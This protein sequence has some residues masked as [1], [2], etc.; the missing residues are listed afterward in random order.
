MRDSK[1]GLRA[2]GLALVAA[3]GL[4]AFMAVAAQAE[5]LT[6]G[7]KPGL[8]LVNGAA[9]A[10]GVAFEVNQ[11]GT[12]ALSVPGRNLGILCTSGVIKGEFKSDTEALGNAKFTGCTAWE[13]AD[14]EKGE[15][16][17]NKLACV[18]HEPIEVTKAK[19][20]PKL[21]KNASGETEKFVLLEED[22]E[23]FTTVVLL[24]CALPEKNVIKGSLAVKVDKS[25]TVEP[26]VLA[27]EEF[28]TLLGDKL[29]F[30]GFAAQL[31]ATGHAKL[32]G[33]DAGKT[34]GVC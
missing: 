1:F 30:G 25:D 18:V 26:L 20:L 31:K 28:Q 16:H 10:A 23:A 8:F 12:G 4:M 27:L 34:V 7:G 5:N 13:F 19:A 22:G 29:T 21:H 11:E 17:K 14:L 3:L 15:T 9:A 6:D 2:F 24:S 32:T 33:A